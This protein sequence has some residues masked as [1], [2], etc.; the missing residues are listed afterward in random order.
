M[1]S[2]AAPGFRRCNGNADGH[3]AFA[4]KQARPAGTSTVE[5]SGTIHYDP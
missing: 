5:L 2:S 3:R 1:L 4:G